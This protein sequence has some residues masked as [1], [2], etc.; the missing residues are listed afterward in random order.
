MNL[1]TSLT[2]ALA[3]LMTSCGHLTGFVGSIE[4]PVPAACRIECAD[5]PAPRNPP[6]EYAADLLGAYRQCSVLHSKCVANFD[7]SPD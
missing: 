3:L 6:R 7:A 4:R 2:A 5:P 1:R